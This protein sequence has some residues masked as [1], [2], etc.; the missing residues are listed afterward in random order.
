MPVFKVTVKLYYKRSNEDEEFMNVP[1]LS[2]DDF[3]NFI[4][5]NDIKTVF[6]NEF[7]FDDAFGI[8]SDCEYDNDTHNLSFKLTINEDTIFINVN[9]DTD[10][11]INDI[12][13]SLNDLSLEDCMYEGLSGAYTVADARDLYPEHFGQ[14]PGEHEHEIEIGLIDYRD[15][16]NP[17]NIMVELVENE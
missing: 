8:L 9:Q 16:D 10:V 17:D 12:K 7:G 6:A 3:N 4:I 14:V 11:M 15:Y 2:E 1:N 5:Q 13:E